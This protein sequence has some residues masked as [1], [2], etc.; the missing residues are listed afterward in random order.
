M[1]PF[2]YS[3]NLLQSI[4]VAIDQYGGNPQ[5][6]GSEPVPVSVCV[7]EPLEPGEISEYK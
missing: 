3:V 6:E 5:G 7:N 4:T 2:V 1:C